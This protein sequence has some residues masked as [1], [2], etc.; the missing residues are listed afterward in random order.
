[1]TGREGGVRRT[2]DSHDVTFVGCRLL[3]VLGP[4]ERHE[5]IC[6]LSP[7]RF[8]RGQ[9]VFN[10]GEPGNCVH[11]VRSGRLD[12]QAATASGRTITLRV[13]H[14]GEMVGEL[15]LVSTHHRRNGR[16]RALEPAETLVMYRHDFE[17]LRRRHPEVDRFMIAALAERVVCASELAVE[18]LLPPETRVWRLLAKLAEAYDP[19][20]IRMSQDDIAHA[21][22]TVRQ[23][24]NRVLRVG[25]SQGVLVAGRGA[26]RILDRDAVE[27]LAGGSVAS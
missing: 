3:D 21:A 2:H 12:V 7:R 20:L 16:V 23:T 8:R 15:A 4:E 14:P 9:T 10:D 24:V 13:V 6:H 27:R 17:E 26:V 22:G 5:F 25:A 18:M 11:L 1:M 19:G